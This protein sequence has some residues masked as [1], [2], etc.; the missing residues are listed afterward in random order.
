MSEWSKEH[1]WRACVRLAYRGFESHPIR[2][3][4]RVRLV[5]RCRHNSLT[6]RGHNLNLADIGEFGLIERIEKLVRSK[7]QTDPKNLVVD[8]GDDAAAFDLD[9]DKHTVATTDVMIENV[10]FRT[11]WASFKDI[12]WKAI[13]VNVS[14]VAAMGAEPKFALVNLGIPRKTDVKSVDQLYRGMASAAETYGLRIAGGDTS[15][16]RSTLFLSVTVLGQVVKHKLVRRSGAQVG[17][18]VVITSTLGAAH[19]GLRVFRKNLDPKKFPYVV[20]KHRTPKARLEESTALNKLFKIHSMIDISDGLASDLTHLCTQ[21]EVGA[22]IDSKEIP[23]H[24][25]TVAVAQALKEDPISYA[26][27]GGEDYEL[28]LTMYPK[29]YEV[30]KRVLR[31]QIHGIGEITKEKKILLLDQKQNSIPLAPSG[32]NHFKKIK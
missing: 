16:S 25:E 21:S 6:L 2:F 1:A 17:D 10:H 4:P 19:A 29:D 22:V 26:T 9:P 20:R 27:N 5:S 12:G 32:F 11:D 13:A 14:D 30:A 18:V 28:L 23:M 24:R 15:A 8:I 31:R 3:P 7:K